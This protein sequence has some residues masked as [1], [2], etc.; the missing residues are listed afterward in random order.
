MKEDKLL[1][2]DPLAEAELILREDF[3]GRGDGGEPSRRKKAEA[4]PRPTHYKVICISMYT[5]DLERLDGMVEALKKRGLTKANRS[6]LIRA[7][8]EQIDLDKVP[9]GM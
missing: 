6:A 3:Y 1:A 4:A 8:L 5:N 9:K 7:A 2:H